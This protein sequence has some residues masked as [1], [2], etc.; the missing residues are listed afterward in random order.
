[1]IGPDES[2]QNLAL[3]LAKDYHQ[4]ICAIVEQ[5]LH[6]FGFQDADGDSRMVENLSHNMMVAMSLLE[7]QN[8]LEFLIGH[9]PVSIFLSII[10]LDI[11]QWRVLGLAAMGRGF[12]HHHQH[13]HQIGMVWQL[14]HAYHTKRCSLWVHSDDGDDIDW[15][16][17]LLC[18]VRSLHHLAHGSGVSYKLPGLGRWRDTKLSYAKGPFVLLYGTAPSYHVSTCPLPHHHCFIESSPW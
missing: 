12:C 16:I 10:Q 9:Q 4:Q 6:L 14:L 3:Y 7:C 8:P 5:H 17:R 13:L 2:V 15:S 11:W 1:M 18:M